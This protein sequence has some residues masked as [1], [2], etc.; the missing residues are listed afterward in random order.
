MY[1]MPSK[2]NF[3]AQNF[4]FGFNPISSWLHDIV[5]KGGLSSDFFLPLIFTT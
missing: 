2:K 5:G 3:A 4:S 1:E